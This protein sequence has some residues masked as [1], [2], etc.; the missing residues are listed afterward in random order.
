M[1]RGGRA[2]C[3]LDLRRIHA[4]NPLGVERAEPLP[5]SQRTHER[6]LD[7][8]LLVEAEPDEQ[9]RRVFA[10]QPVGLDVTGPLEKSV[11]SC[12]G[13]Y[14]IAPRVEAVSRAAAWLLG[15]A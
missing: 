8:H 5:E 11:R 9:R 4:R 2:K 6:P 10:D 14:G 13:R 15:C 3:S 12:H 1:Q 7:G